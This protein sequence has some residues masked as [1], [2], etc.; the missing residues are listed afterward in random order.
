M[1]V[2]VNEKQM[3]ESACETEMFETVVA[4]TTT[5]LNH[6]DALLIAIALLV[7]SHSLPVKS[8]NSLTA[9]G[10]KVKNAKCL[11]HLLYTSQIK[12]LP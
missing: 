5:A 11:F 3:L 10:E 1:C 4:L 2:G 8:L 6:V 9:I 12:V 7:L